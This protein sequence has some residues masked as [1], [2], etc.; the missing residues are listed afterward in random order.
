M[1]SF[2][3]WW[4]LEFSASSC[5][6]WIFFLDRICKI[7][8]LFLM[9]ETKHGITEHQQSKQQPARYTNY[10]TAKQ[11]N[12]KEKRKKKEES[13]KYSV[14]IRI[15]NNCY[16][17]RSIWIPSFSMGLCSVLLLCNCKCRRFVNRRIVEKQSQMI[18]PSQ[19][20]YEHK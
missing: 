20:G 14:N 7:I 9:C 11:S 8:P 10:S 19:H 3:F 2:F 1:L 15:F 16:S 13:I 4:L 12:K 5:S 6:M 18:G 17:S